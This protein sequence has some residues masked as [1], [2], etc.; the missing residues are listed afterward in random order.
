VGKVRVALVGVGN[1]ASA[2]LQGIEYLHDVVE[3]STEPAVDIMRVLRDANAEIVVSYH[4]VSAEQARIVAYCRVA[5]REYGI[6]DRP[7]CCEIA[8]PHGIQ[9]LHAV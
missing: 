8:A 1:C 6:T 9:P 7:G 4:P 2:L 3:E 5:R